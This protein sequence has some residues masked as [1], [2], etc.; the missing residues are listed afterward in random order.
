MSNS[1]GRRSSFLFLIAALMFLASCDSNSSG[2]GD[3]I[4]LT[5]EISEA[6]DGKPI[7]FTFSSS[8]I[9]IGTL[10][11]VRCNC[12]I[13]IGPYLATQ[14]FTKEEI[15]SVNVTAAELVMLF[16]INKDHTFL[17]AAILKLEGIKNTITEVANQPN[18]PSAR[19]SSLIVLPN[20]DVAGFFTRPSFGAILQIDAI[21]LDDDE[22]YQIGLVLT[23]LI[24]VAGI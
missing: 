7:Q 23:V 5:H 20:R 17:N 13:D 22:N 16:P 9:Q 6:A 10:Q 14:S 2:G 3:T 18:F 8:Q 21:T 4:F 12:D 24:E 1:L 11:D 19:E 15:I